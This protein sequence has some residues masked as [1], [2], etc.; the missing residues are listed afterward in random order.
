MRAIDLFCG[1][2]GSSLGAAAA[3]AEIVAGFDI[4]PVARWVYRANFPHARFYPC[5]LA[6]LGHAG[7]CR[8]VDAMRVTLSRAGVAVGARATARA[9]DGARAVG[10]LG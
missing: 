9:T 1:A 2:G 3:G 4:W 7:D 5:D 6:T 8:G 10:L